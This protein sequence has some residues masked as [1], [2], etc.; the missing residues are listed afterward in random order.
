MR[1]EKREMLWKPESLHFSS[2]TKKKVRKQWTG[3]KRNNE[4]LTIQASTGYFSK[5]VETTFLELRPN[6][7]NTV[8]YATCIQ[9]TETQGFVVLFCV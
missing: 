6:P 2:T 3:R 5:K 8:P 9:V 1:N 7:F 4:A